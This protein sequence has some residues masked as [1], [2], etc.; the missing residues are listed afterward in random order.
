MTHSKRAFIAGILLTFSAMVSHASVGTTV[1]NFLKDDRGGRIGAYGGA[2]T[3]FYGDLAAA[4][5]NP[6]GLAGLHR[7]EMVLEKDDL[8]LDISENYAAI[9]G[10]WR[11]RYGWSLAFTGI[12]YGQTLKTS[13]SDPSGVTGQTF[14]GDD[15]S[16]TAGL[17]K[18]FGWRGN[19][20]IGAAVKWYRLEI[21]SFNSSGAALDLGL[22]WRPRGRRKFLPFQI[23]LSVLNIGPDAQFR[24]VKEPIPTTLRL[25][26]AY[27]NEIM[28]APYEISLDVVGGEG[29]DAHVR[30]GGGILLFDILS[31]RLGYDGGQEIQQG[32][33]GGLGMSWKDLSVDYAY[34][35][36]GSFGSRSKLSLK[37]NFGK[38]KSGR[39]PDFMLTDNIRFSKTKDPAPVI[40]PPIQDDRPILVVVAPKETPVTPDYSV[41]PIVGV[42]YIVPAVQEN[43]EVWSE[44]FMRIISIEGLRF[45][46]KG[47]ADLLIDM[48]NV[49]QEDTGKWSGIVFLKSSKPELPKAFVLDPSA[50]DATIAAVRISDWLSEQLV[51]N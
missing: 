20:S 44:A 6:A 49:Y 23:G 2:G 18:R 43:K 30:V 21:D 1:G 9:G 22:Q 5:A 31:L 4:S 33:T 17:G 24:N 11:D 7:Y 16:V 13:L 35:P 45:G 8:I 10:P 3:A 15:F 47:D 39:E 14:S 37:Y 50:Q 32:I 51:G 12:N 40:V 46:T 38:E 36:Y 28:S 25:G 27:F 41:K 34:I 29:E 19:L 26:A 48:S 42:A